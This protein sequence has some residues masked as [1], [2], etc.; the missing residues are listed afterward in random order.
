MVNLKKRLFNCAT[1]EKHNIN[2]KTSALQFAI[3]LRPIIL[4]YLHKIMKFLH[5]S[6]KIK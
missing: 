2:I 1:T 3:L 5:E 4:E 6:W